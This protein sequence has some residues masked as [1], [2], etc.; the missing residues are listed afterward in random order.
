MVVNLQPFV[1]ERAMEAKKGIF[2]HPQ[3]AEVCS[4]ICGALLRNLRNSS[5]QFAEI[6]FIKTGVSYL[7]Q[8]VRVAIEFVSVGTP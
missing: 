4:A 7:F 6:L 8:F 3:N 5:P 1:S 2:P